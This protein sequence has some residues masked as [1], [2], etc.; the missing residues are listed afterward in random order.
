MEVKNKIA[1][2]LATYN[3]EKFIQEQ[4]DSLFSQ[5]F[6]DFK[7]FVR[8]DGSTDNTIR[9]IQESVQKYPNRIMIM[10]DETPHRGAKDSFLWLLEHVNAKYYMF[11]DQDDVWLPFKIEHT[12]SRMEAVETKNP[13]KAI[14]I[15]T[16]LRIVDANLNVIKPSFWNWGKFN[17]DLNKRFN[18]AALGNVFTGCTMMIN[19]KVK[20]FVFPVNTLVK[21][22]DEWIGLAVT[23]YG[24]VENLKEQTILYRQ[25]GNNVCSA[26]EEKE[27]NLKRYTNFSFNEWY[28]NRR[29]IL[30]SVDYGPKAKAFVFKTIYSLIRTFYHN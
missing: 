15:H 4:L 26:G 16:D 13:Q 8:D 10:H 29:P 1:I 6:Q 30:D 9:I 17:V 12:L 28:S 20:D 21:L 5:T 11:C 18:F 3:G 19:N 7:I 23:K 25:H 14:M 22:H 2:L 24:K 27:F